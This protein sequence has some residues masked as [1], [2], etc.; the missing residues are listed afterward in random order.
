MEALLTLLE[1]LDISLQELLEL[2][3]VDDDEDGDEGAA[4]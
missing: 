3:N 4:A 2:R 1:E